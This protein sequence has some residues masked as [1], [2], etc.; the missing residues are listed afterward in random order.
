VYINRAHQVVLSKWLNMY[1]RPIILLLLC[2][3]A[4][5]TL[6]SVLPR[7]G[8]LIG[9]FRLLLIS[10]PL[11]MNNDTYYDERLDFVPRL[12]TRLTGFES[13]IQV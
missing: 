12:A 5:L 10:E 7:S 4:A 13:S 1:N 3:V 9:H 8:S 6:N 2:V 11:G